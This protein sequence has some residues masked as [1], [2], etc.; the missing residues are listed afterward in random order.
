MNC[1]KCGDKLA[2]TA[3][4]CPSCGM[5]VKVLGASAIELDDEFLEQAKQLNKLLITFNKAIE[6]RDH[7]DLFQLALSEEFQMLMN[8][9]QEA[10]E[11]LDSFEIDDEAT[12]ALMSAIPTFEREFRIYRQTVKLITVTLAELSDDQDDDDV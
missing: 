12:A 5:A 9:A 1:Q 3:R 7:E 10:L 11:F 8:Q 4:F 6:P 2:K